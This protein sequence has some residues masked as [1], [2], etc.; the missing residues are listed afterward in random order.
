MNRKKAPYENE[1]VTLSEAE[2]GKIRFI[3][4]FFKNTEKF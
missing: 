1:G 2:G 3:S 4:D